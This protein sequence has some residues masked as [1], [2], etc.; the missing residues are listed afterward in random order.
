MGTLV[1]T[2]VFTSVAFTLW[3]FIEA[4]F[5]WMRPPRVFTRW[6]VGFVCA[7]I[8]AGVAVAL[9]FY[10][11]DVY[12]LRDNIDTTQDALNELIT[13][14]ERYCWCYNLTKSSLVDSDIN[15][16]GKFSRKG[17]DTLLPSLL[18]VSLPIIGIFFI[19]AFIS[20]WH[21]GAKLRMFALTL[22]GVLISVALLPA[23]TVSDTYRIIRDDIDRSVTVITNMAAGYTSCTTMISDGSNIPADPIECPLFGEPT[24]LCY[25]ADSV[26]MQT[27]QPVGYADAPRND[28]NV[29]L[30]YNYSIPD[31]PCMNHCLYGPDDNSFVYLYVRICNLQNDMAAVM[32]HDVTE[33]RIKTLAFVYTTLVGC[34]GVLVVLEMNSFEVPSNKDTELRMGEW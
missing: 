20:P 6:G 19:L 24:I 7:T 27:L 11:A 22:V 17:L 12:D 30:P 32:G 18:Y 16:L 15:Q 34:L 13:H 25:Y 10:Y 26:F 28:A 29:S 8:F 31:G 4:W 33:F 5:L 21:G 2:I 1:N 23:I 3:L 14:V 9:G